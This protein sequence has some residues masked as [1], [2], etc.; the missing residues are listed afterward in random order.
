MS[1]GW[2]LLE[3]AMKKY[4]QVLGING[5]IYQAHF[6]LGVLYKKMGNIS[7]A[8][9]SYQSALNIKKTYDKGWYALGIAHKENGDIDN[10]KKAFE[11]TVRLNQKYYKAHKS[12]GEIFIDLQQYDNA[13]KSFKT[14]I[15]Y[16]SNYAAAYHALGI[17]YGKGKLEDY[18]RSV[19]ALEKAVELNRR[20][21]LSWYSLAESYNELGECDKAKEAALEA[22]DLKKNFG[23]GWF[24]LGIA[25]YCNATGNKNSA[26]NHFERARND[27]QWRKMAEY[28]IDRVKNPEKFE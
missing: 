6:Q 19:E 10:A 3:A 23:G 5:R 13:V 4:K 21:V 28:E 2:D 11:E 9:Q 7:Q 22:V 18:R 16:K 25:E 15:S 24:Q 27:R 12:L 26:I 1:Y 8:I 17:T 14:A 20:E